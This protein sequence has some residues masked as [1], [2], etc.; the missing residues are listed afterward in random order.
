[1]DSFIIR[2][3]FLQFFEGKNHKAVPSS[4]LFPKDDPSVLLTT[5]GMQQ[6]KPYFKGEKD[7]VAD[8]GNKNL[9]SI[10]KCFRTSDIDQVG[11]SSHLTFFEMLGNFSI[12]GYFKDRAIELMWKFATFE[13]GIPRQNLSATYFGGDEKTPRDDDTRIA[14]LKFL[15]ED[16]LAPGLRSD[17]FWGPTGDEGPCG[18]SSEFFYQTESGEKLEIWTL[19]F[20]AYYCDSAGNYKQL[21]L[22]G[23]D[24]GG[25]I[26]RMLGVLQNKPSVFETDLFRPIIQSIEQITDKV[27]G[28]SLSDDRRIR[29]IADHIRASTFLISDG[30][31]PSNKD[32]GYILRRLIRRAV[33][34]GRLL[35]K[36][37]LSLKEVACVV[38]DEYK[39][40]YQELIN[41]N[42]NILTSEEER[43]KK[44]LNSGLKKYKELGKEIS[45]EDAFLL[46]QSFGFPIELIKELAKGDG[47]IVDEQGFFEELKKHQDISRAI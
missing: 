6:F 43:F 11:D 38:I 17:T 4:S 34:H 26:E 8:F 20:M 35:N 30:A 45:G 12:G 10:Q 21:G 25:G 44:T 37:I 24:T 41:A 14:W 1:M 19:V 36:N 9:V 7:P 15:P 5:A 32:R 18:T 23:V 28:Q 2:Q 40:E 13:L 39:N 47:K 29:I 22:T 31:L 3:K 46:F 27:Y 42:L 33:T 16:K